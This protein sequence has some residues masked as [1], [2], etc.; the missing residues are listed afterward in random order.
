MGCIVLRKSG[1]AVLALQH[2]FYFLD[3]ITKKISL[4]ADPESHLPANRF[5]DGKCDCAGR[6]W[7]GTLFMDQNDSNAKNAGTLYCMDTD[8]SI[9]AALRDI[10]ISN[11]IT[12]SPDNKIMYFIDTPT[13]Q[14]AAFDFDYITG[15]IKNKRVVI[16]IPESEGIPDGM[17]ADIEGMLWIA[18]WGGSNVSRWN[19]YTGRLL[20]KILLPVSGATSCVFGGSELDELYITT[21]RAGLNEEDIIKQP[22][23][24]GVFRIKTGIKGLETFKFKG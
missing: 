7:A 20:D 6:L 12:W 5:N 11:G 19:P 2:G 17:T 22:H 3:L 10:T 24:G 15:N 14:V 13:R 4:I 16:T 23:A 8:L 21:A 1:G 18:Q 9:R